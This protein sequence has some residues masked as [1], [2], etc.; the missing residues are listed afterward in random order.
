[1]SS[2]RRTLRQIAPGKFPLG[3]RH[4]PT[5]IPGGALCAT[6][7]IDSHLN[8]IVCTHIDTPVW[9]R[10]EAE[11]GDRGAHPC[12][13]CSRVRVALRD[14]FA[15]T[16]LEARTHRLVP[17][18][19]GNNAPRDPFNGRGRFETNAA[20]AA[21][22]FRVPSRSTTAVRNCAR[23][24]TLAVARDTLDRGS[25]ARAGPAFARRRYFIVRLVAPSR[26]RLYPVKI[27]IFFLSETGERFRVTLA[28]DYYKSRTGKT[29]FE[30]S[31]P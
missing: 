29:G 1:M 21:R 24:A 26:E 14:L 18:R 9:A 30:H 11:R 6:D 8:T 16:R 7:E 17:R 2:A 20:S 15:R 13:D 23:S 19:L 12:R 22:Q 28:V 4:S 25:V 10:L 31:H 5:Q 27:V 3:S